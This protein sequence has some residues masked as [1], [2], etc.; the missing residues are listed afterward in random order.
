[1]PEPGKPTLVR[2]IG[3]WSLAALTINCIIGSAVFGLPS[4]IS[5]VVGNASP[6]AWLFAA[7]ATALVMAC[8]AEVSSR[9]DQTG[10]VYLYSRAAFGRTAGIA[11]AWFGLLARLTAIATNANLFLIY[12]GQ[13]WPAATNQIPRATILSLLLGFLAWIN[14][15]GVRG[16]AILSNL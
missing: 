4:Q 5:K 10:G 15:S 11:V 6:F 12:L 7:A 3:A 14:Y 16:G 2:A 13:F 8:F 1:M 9:F